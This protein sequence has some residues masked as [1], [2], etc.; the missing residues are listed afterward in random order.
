[1]SLLWT[2]G[3]KSSAL[4]GDRSILDG[5]RVHPFLW[6]PLSRDGGT[7]LARDYAKSIH[8][9]YIN[10]IFSARLGEERVY[11]RPRHLNEI[12]HIVARLFRRPIA[13]LKDVF[14]RRQRARYTYMTYIYGS[15]KNGS[16]RCPFEASVCPERSVIG[17]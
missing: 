11:C 7:T 6:G 12:G 8:M 3:I 2:S 9:E 5:A 16:T 1:M 13:Q 10:N 15:G 17:S 4:G 14:R